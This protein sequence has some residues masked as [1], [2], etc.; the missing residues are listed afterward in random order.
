MLISKEKLNFLGFKIHGD[1]ASEN[2]T[3]PLDLERV[4]FDLC[5]YL[6]KHKEEGRLLGLLK[7]WFKVHGDKVIVL[8]FKKLRDEYFKQTGNDC[9]WLR[10][11]AYYNMSLRRHNWKVLTTSLQRNKN[12]FY[13]VANEKM[14]LQ[15]LKRWGQEPF[16]PKR[17]NLKIHK[18]ALR[19][20]E[21][22]V[23]SVEELIKSNLQYQNRYR[24]GQNVKS[25]IYTFWDKGFFSSIKDFA[26]FIKYDYE[27]VR[28][29]LLDYRKLV[30]VG[31]VH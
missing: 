18:N 15:F 29:N 1:F 2:L 19:L 10:Y 30:E 6:D 12:P 7:S 21:E 23:A 8:K 20:R 25:D 28:K 27:T 24:Y 16:L 17:S 13:A 31:I 5:L 22:D 9:E 26:E 3:T 4:L 14:A 11:F